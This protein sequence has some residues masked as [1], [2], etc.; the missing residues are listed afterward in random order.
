MLQEHP[1]DKATFPAPKYVFE[2]SHYH[3][4]GVRGN[5][6]LLIPQLLSELPPEGQAF[7][8]ESR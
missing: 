8:E 7:S 4:E 3:R 1:T 5:G 2:K 6:H